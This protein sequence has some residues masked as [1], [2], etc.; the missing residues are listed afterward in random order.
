MSGMNRKGMITSAA[1]S[2][3]IQA[4]DRAE[5]LAIGEVALPPIGSSAGMFLSCRED[6]RLVCREAFP[7]HDSSSF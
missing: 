1:T 3:L 7:T 6:V 5:K 2:D 4:K